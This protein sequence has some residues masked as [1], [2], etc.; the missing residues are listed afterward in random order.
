[1]IKT[2][3]IKRS[4]KIYKTLD[5]IKKEIGDGKAL[6]N[7]EGLKDGELML[8]RY[9][10]S[11][12]IRSVLGQVTNTPEKK[13]ITLG[14]TQDDLD[15]LRPK[16]VIQVEKY[17]NAFDPLTNRRWEFTSSEIRN[18]NFSGE[19]TIIDPKEQITGVPIRSHFT[20]EDAEAGA[21]LNGKTYFNV[22]GLRAHPGTAVLKFFP[23]YRADEYSGVLNEGEDLK[24]NIP[25]GEE[26]F[27]GTGRTLALMK[28]NMGIEFSL[29]PFNGQTIPGKWLRDGS[30]E[31]VIPRNVRAS[32][33]DILV[34]IAPG[35][36]RDSQPKFQRDFAIFFS[37]FL[38][39][40]AWSGDY[41]DNYAYDLDY[42][43]RP[44]MF[45]RY[46]A[47]THVF[48]DGSTREEIIPYDT[49]LIEKY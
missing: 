34:S 1:M 48:E 24:R 10:H 9:P 49:S 3:Q 27:N 39:V 21:P 5:E 30:V 46:Y 31:I 12:S 35:S 16:A 13:A 40:N 6:I 41:I 42:P 8:F 2:I 22:F 19:I 20:M 36:W 7:S 43:D 18:Y 23:Y 14:I 28:K 25:L 45:E 11:S 17:A 37:R 4:D 38:I 29:K 26:T 47:Y 33:F 44:L 32:S 15:A